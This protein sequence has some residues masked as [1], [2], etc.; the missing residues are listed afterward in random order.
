MLSFDSFDMSAVVKRGVPLLASPGKEFEEEPTGL[1]E[2]ASLDP[3]ERIA[4]QKRLL[5][6]KL[7]LGTEFMDGVLPVP[8][9]CS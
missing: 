4:R 1:A 9:C 6:Q 7:G 3:K 8:C 5:K 2:A